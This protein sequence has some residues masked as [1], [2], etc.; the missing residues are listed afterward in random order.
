MEKNRLEQ[1]ELPSY[2]VIMTKL[3]PFLLSLLFVNPLKSQIQIIDRLTN[4]PISY[5]HIKFL[6]HNEDKISDYNGYF[7]LDSTSTLNDSI[8]VSCIGYA[9]KICEI[10]NLSPDAKI[11]LVPI[12]LE[13][14]EVVV[15]KKKGQFKLMNLGITKK[16]KTKFYDYSITAS[17]G[18]IRAT[19][20]PNEYSVPGVLKN[21]N[22]YTTDDG[23][24]D[25]HFRIHVYGVS[26]MEIKPGTELTSSNIVASGTTGNEWIKID[27][28][29]E[30]ILV[31]ENGCFI[32]VEWF[33]HPESAY[34]QDTLKKKG[35]TKVDGKLKDT[36]YTKVRSGNGI[37]LG[38]RDEPYKV[39][40]NKLWYKTHLSEK[41]INLCTSYTDESIFNI[42]DTLSNGNV[43]IINESNFYL[44]VPCIN[45]E[46][47]FPKEKIA[48]EFENPKKRKL[49]NIERVKEDR[50]KYPQSSVV[51]LFNSL[52]RAVEDDQIIYILKYLCVY[53]DGE[54]DNLLSTIKD[55]ESTTG[56][57]FSEKDKKQ[58]MN[59]FHIIIKNLNEDALIK[60]DSHHFELKV[61]NDCYNLTVDNRKWK[62]HP[63]THRVMK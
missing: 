5:T 37:I 41:W 25:A 22:L 58:I 39:A 8:R 59:H 45:V 31:P 49:N 29:N 44:H 57:Y 32:G 3:L 35:V 14:K 40:K 10:Q 30:R 54:L 24:P 9:P 1:N 36:V 47:S 63:Y 53:A 56:M 51:E 61:N 18:T 52:Y 42:P 19:Y 17:I 48:L 28:T 26:P 34:F 13:I 60:I 11:P 55:T 21:I 20:I 43:R 50:F 27:L 33:D 16:P 2:I 46:I 23:Y 12:A 6:N 15:S 62:I 4:K 38:S 7:L